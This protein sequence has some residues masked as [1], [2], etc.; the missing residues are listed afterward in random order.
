MFYDFS[1]RQRLPKT[2]WVTAWRIEEALAT[3][4][5]HAGRHIFQMGR[6]Q[7]EQNLWEALGVYLLDETVHRNQDMCH[8]KL[9]TERLGRDLVHL[10]KR[11]L[12]S[13]LRYLKANHHVLEGKM[14]G[15]LSNY[16]PKPRSRTLIA[17]LRSCPHFHRHAV[18]AHR[19]LEQFKVSRSLSE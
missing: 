18:G 19:D 6:E 3:E 5:V 12:T 14:R 13:F 17:C 1:P 4:L 10:V 11:E 15:P 9:Q 7:I 16:V 2:Y 8:H